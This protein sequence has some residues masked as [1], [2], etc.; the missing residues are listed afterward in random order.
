M[1]VKMLYEKNFEEFVAQST[2]AV[3]DF[4]ADWCMP[5]RIMAPRME[6]LSEEIS[7]A[8]FGKI[9]VDESSSIAQRFGIVSIPTIII[10][11]NGAQVD[12]VVGTHSK[13]SV[14]STIKKYL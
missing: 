7:G 12:E 10:F 14:K 3:V 5:C 2:V 13:D 6:E 1:A 4:Y 11:K 9:N 8:F